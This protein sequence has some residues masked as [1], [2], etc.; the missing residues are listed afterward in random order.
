MSKLFSIPDEELFSET[1]VGCTASYF[2]KIIWPPLFWGCVL[3][4]LR[5]PKGGCCSI[6]DDLSCSCSMNKILFQLQKG[7]MV[8]YTLSELNIIKARQCIWDLSG[9]GIMYNVHVKKACMLPIYFL[10]D[11]RKCSYA[12]LVQ[13]ESWYH[14][15]LPGHLVSP[16]AC[17]GP[18]MSTVV[19]YFCCHNDN[20]SVL[21]Y[22]TL[23]VVNTFSFWHSVYVSQCNYDY[24]SFL[25]VY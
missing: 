10:P 15:L 7:N 9:A 1:P 21:L 16:L 25:L 6:S 11:C 8:S 22:F 3:L 18:W 2:V 13:T 24:V 4:H 12:F 20:A 17:R 5:S 23:K 14:W 19:L